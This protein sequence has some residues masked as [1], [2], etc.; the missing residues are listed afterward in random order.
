MVII[1]P[2][3]APHRMVNAGL[4]VSGLL[5]I[6]LTAGYT[7]AAAITE[8]ALPNPIVNSSSQKLAELTIEGTVK[9]AAGLPMPG[10]SILLKEIG[11]AHV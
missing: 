7:N 8:H 6:L 1:K 3:S 4:R 9:D 2:R 5:C 11:R 10:V